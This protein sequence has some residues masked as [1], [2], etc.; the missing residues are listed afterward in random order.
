M[1]YEEQL[2]Y[3]ADIA[4]TPHKDWDEVVDK[5]ELDYNPDSV[6]KAW[7]CTKFGGYAVYKHFMDNPACSTTLPEEMDRL[8]EL[9]ETFFKE[10]V[11]YAD[12]LREYRNKLREESRFENLKDT[13]VEALISTHKY[14]LTIPTPSKN[15]AALPSRTAVLMLSDIHYGLE[16]DNQVNFYNIAIAKER[17]FEVAERTISLCNEHKVDNLNIC[18]L[19]DIVNGIINVSNRIEQEEDIMTQIIESGN[20]LTALISYVASKVSSVSVY[21]VWGNH[22]RIPS[23]NAAKKGDVVNR[24]NLERLIY[25]YIKTTLPDNIKV[26]T[27]M[28]DDYLYVKIG[29][30]KALLEHGDKGNRNNPVVDYTTILGE[31]PDIILRGHDHTFSVKNI[32]DTVVVTNGSLIGTDNYALSIRQRTKPSQTLVMLDSTNK[33]DICCYELVVD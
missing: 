6:R 18:L 15:A 32:N 22:A 10:K 26:V 4:E 25:H 5:L 12:K 29:E 3:L 1:T 19:G 16:V 17:L 11:R 8:E 13:M 33:S 21:T 31:K 30:K 9:R 20:L 14:P 27:S 7:A 2:K 24:E 28:N 23:V